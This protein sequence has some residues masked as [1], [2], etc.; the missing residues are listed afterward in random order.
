[1]VLVFAAPARF[2]PLLS[3]AH[4]AE[5]AKTK[6]RSANSKK[7]AAKKKKAAA[8]K[9]APKK[10]K[11]AAKTTRKKKKA[12]SKKAT[13]KKKTSRKKTTAK[14]KAAR[15]KA[16]A[17]PPVASLSGDARIKAAYQAWRR[18]DWQRLAQID[19][20]HSSHVLDVY[21]RYWRI[22]GQL[23]RGEASDAEIRQF[24]AQHK[25]AAVGEQ[26][27]AAWLRNMAREKRWRHFNKH[28]TRLQNPTREFRCLAWQAEIAA[29]GTQKATALSAASAVWLEETGGGIAACEDVFDILSGWHQTPANN[30]WWRFRRLIDSRTP[31]RARIALRSAAPNQPAALKALERILKKP[32]Q[33]LR[34][35]PANFAQTRVGRE[36]ALAAV[37][38]LARQSPLSAWRRL[39]EF[40]T[41]LSIDERAAAYASLGLHGA[42][43]R[44]PQAAQWFNEVGALHI[45]AHQRAWRVRAFLRNQDWPGVA[46]AIAMMNSEE[47]KKPA[48]IY[49]LGRSLQEQGEAE[50]AKSYFRRLQ[51]DSSFY[52]L[53][54]REA[55]GERFKL[56][57]QEAKPTAKELNRARR[58]PALKRA[59]ALF[60]LDLRSLGRREW[61]WGLRDQDS[62]F[63]IAAAHLALQAGHPDRAIYAAERADRN[64]H[65]QLRYL[66]PYRKLIEPQARQQKV[67]LAW[68]YGLMRQESRFMVPAR[69]SAGAQGLMQVMP[70]TG[71][72]VAKKIGLKNYR[73][74]QLAEPKTNV[75]IGTS[76][77]KMLVEQ[78]GGQLVLASAAYNAG[79]GRARR[80]RD[81]RALEGAIYAETIPFDETRDYVR[82]VLANTVIYDTIINR[83]P[84]SLKRRLGTIPP[85]P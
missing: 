26:M 27:L 62:D 51:D 40:E 5:A 16:R 71:K 11:A 48:W 80:W 18:G 59:L 33:Y 45:S 79:P 6:K 10:K 43:S 73:A 77:M 4:A 81:S 84:Q 2:L 35:K 28:M 52:G 14:K 39:I 7:A 37:M 49:W 75:L 36:L 3:P 46:H 64:G 25:N 66:L 56:P 68:I 50:M 83:R 76:Y 8:K 9:A 19:R 13:A 15:K 31:E 41:K 82:K 61:A 12:A 20:S 65:F 24:I 85:A 38:R 67:D 63:Q 22:L 55:L 69:S 1:M 23:G 29:G 57:P 30:R 72:W 17:L 44:L 32:E 78:F 60:K 34:N 21:V 47:Q 42:Q 58:N 70:A 53:L 54:A 74:N